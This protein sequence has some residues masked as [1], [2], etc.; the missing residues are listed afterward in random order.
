MSR[1]PSR[2]R[3]PSP[4]R[5]PSEDRVTDLFV[6][7]LSGNVTEAHLEEVFNCYGSVKQVEMPRGGRA[8]Q[9]RKF[10]YV[11]FDTVEEAE[12]AM[13]FLNGAQLD[14]QKIVVQP[15]QPPRRMFSLSFSTSAPPLRR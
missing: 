4:R 5:G 15:K 11:S 3:S 8:G 14:G 12:R 6:G 10:A 13:D 1:S 9:R 7:Q 2:S